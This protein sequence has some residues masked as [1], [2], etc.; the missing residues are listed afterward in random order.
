MAICALF[1]PFS[2]V[3]SFIHMVWSGCFSIFFFCFSMIKLLSSSSSALFPGF[4]RAAAHPKL[5]PQRRGSS[6]S[7][8]ESNDGG[9]RNIMISWGVRLTRN[10]DPTQSE[11]K[12]MPYWLPPLRHRQVAD[13]RWLLATPLAQSEMKGMPYWLPPLRHRQVARTHTYTHA[14][15]HTCQVMASLERIPCRPC[16]IIRWLISDGF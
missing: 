4:R 5:R 1:R 16:G 7:L 12:G 13:F 14:H 9:T 8:T 2:A 3:V 15:T 11:M 10:S 6:L